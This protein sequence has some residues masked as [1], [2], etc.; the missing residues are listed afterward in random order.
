[1]ASPAT[2]RRRGSTGGSPARAS[3]LSSRQ[4]KHTASAAGS[5]I[6]ADAGS[7]PAGV[8]IRT[9]NAGLPCLLA[10]EA[11]VLANDG[12]FDELRSGVIG[13]READGESA[14]VEIADLLH[15]RDEFFPGQV[16]AGASEAFDQDLGGDEALETREGVILLAGRCLEQLLIFLDHA[17][18]QVPRKRHDLGDADAAP[19][20][21]RLVGKRLATD[22]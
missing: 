7:K 17:G 20:G 4:T 16:V 12:Q 19:G 6:A 18:G 8:F 9:L 11:L 21:S 5:A 2:S 14:D 15:R 1:M 13:R 3:I 22:E 10:Q